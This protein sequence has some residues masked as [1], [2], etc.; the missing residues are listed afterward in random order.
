MG[1]SA[2]IARA[3]NDVA[4]IKRTTAEAAR[5]TGNT[6]EAAAFLADRDPAGVADGIALDA[7]RILSGDAGE[8]DPVRTAAAF[9]DHVSKQIEENL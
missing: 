5:F 7:V 3:A 2:K 6:K 1:A 4:E 9:L 8:A